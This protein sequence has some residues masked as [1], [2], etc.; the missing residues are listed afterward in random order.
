MNFVTSCNWDL[1]WW[2]GLHCGEALVALANAQVIL[3]CSNLGLVMNQ[4]RSVW[5]AVGVA[6]PPSLWLF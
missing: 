1:S 4:S 5:L 2:L 6:R 3:T